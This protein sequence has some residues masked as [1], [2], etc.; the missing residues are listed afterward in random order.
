MSTTTTV[1][2]PRARRRR[3]RARE[4]PPVVARRASRAASRTMT[5]SASAST[6]RCDVS[7]CRVVRVCATMASLSTATSRAAHRYGVVDANS[8]RG[9]RRAAPRR[10]WDAS[11]LSSSSSSSSSLEEDLIANA[12]AGDDAR[13]IAAMNALTSAYATSPSASNDALG[14]SFSG[15]WRLIYSTKSAFDA[16]AP[17]GRR[18]D[19]TAPGLEAVFK[20]A[21]GDGGGKGT[22]AA[23]AAVTA[24]SSPIQRAV[25]SNLTKGGF[26]VLQGVRLTGDAT[27]H[28]VD[29]CVRFG[30]GYGYFRLSASASLEPESSPR[31]GTINYKFD[32]AYVML[33]KPFEVRLPYPVPFKLLGDE[34][35]GYLELKYASDRVRVVKG[36]KGTNFVF[37]REDSMDALPCANELFGA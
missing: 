35:A 32:N 9:A 29:Q 21:F 13:T 15:V 6:S 27:K 17:L 34:A 18:E 3:T 28:R 26:A 2:T 8:R 11:A 30:D 22:D 19:N 10:R 7:R 25:L 37:V 4:T 24:S 14:A 23:S 1:S 33:R 20:A 31:R 16:T 5:R 12:D 36:N